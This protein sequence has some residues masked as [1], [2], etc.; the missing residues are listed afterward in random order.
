[1]LVAIDQCLFMIMHDRELVP[2]SNISENGLPAII[3]ESSAWLQRAAASGAE[4]FDRRWLHLGLELWLSHDVN[5]SLIPS[6]GD[7]C[8]RY[9]CDN[10]T[11]E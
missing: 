2:V 3:T 4:R 10:D 1:M 7:Y 9:D 8:E 11:R 5:Q 6:C